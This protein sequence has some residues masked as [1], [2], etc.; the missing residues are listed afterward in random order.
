MRDK[1]IKLNQYLVKDKKEHIISGGIN[2]MKCRFADI[3]YD[4]SNIY[5]SVE[6]RCREY[7][8]PDDAICDEKIV[9]TNEDIESE[10][11]DGNYS[12][13]Y[14][15]FIAL[16][17]KISDKLPLH[18]AFLLHSAVFEVSGVGIALAALSGTGKTTHMMLWQKLLCERLTIVNGDKPFVRFFDDEP[19][20][21]YAYGSPWN[22]KEGLSRNMRTPLRHICFI[23]R[24][25]ENSCEPI[26]TDEALN[27]LFN[28]LYI[29]KDPSAAAG[30]LALTNRLITSC[31]LWRIRCNMDI[32]AAKTAYNAIFGDASK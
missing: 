12:P 28:Q 27:L 2:T 11:N 26:E 29:P 18:N 20:I 17:R 9:I 25:A 3:N 19:N 5:T 7:V 31:K 14:L 32:S 13:Q 4:I 24:A 8:V 16:C 15:E 10:N 23:E 22:G 21:P 1:I 6:K 30:A